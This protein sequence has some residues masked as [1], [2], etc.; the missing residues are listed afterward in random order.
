MIQADSAGNIYLIGSCVLNGPLD[1]NGTASTAPS[2]GQYPWYIVR[3]HANGQYHWHYY[4]T[5]IT[6]TNR[7]LKLYGNNELYL[8]GGLSDSTS[9]GSF[10]FNKPPS[11]FN[12]DYI[13]ARLD[14]S[15]N[16]IWAQQRPI[17]G[18]TQGG[19]YFNSQFNTAV[20]DSSFYLFCETV[21]NSIWGGGGVATSNS[22][23][24]LVTMVRYDKATGNATWAKT[25]NGLF[26]TAQQ[27]IDDG[28][29][30]WV[31]GN[32]RD[33]NAQTFDTISVPTSGVTSYLPYVAKMQVGTKKTV[34]TTPVG[35]VNEWLLADISVAPNPA[36]STLTIRG[37]KEGESIA[38]FDM[39]GRAVLQMS[40]TG[41]KQFTIATGNLS[42]GVYFL[43]VRSGANSLVRRIILE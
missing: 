31:T 11:L 27:V 24:H 38:L 5:D 42:K 36:I 17:T 22:N 19:V 30:L 43:E 7:G 1:F 40:N 15:G 35:L 41:S 12:S 3:Y 26:T 9:L 16:L 21:G 37:L 34:T 28:V 4:L 18:S 39:S 2:G 10:H 32:G 25:V 8:S 13:L 29:S 33:S 23:R 20:V 14:S 6:C